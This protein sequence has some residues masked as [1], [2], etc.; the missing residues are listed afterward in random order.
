MGR[1]STGSI[2]GCII[3]TFFLDVGF[4]C[5]TPHTPTVFFF[6]FGGGLHAN[7]RLESTQSILG[8]ALQ[9]AGHFCGNGQTTNP[10]PPFSEQ[11]LQNSTGQT[12]RQT[13]PIGFESQIMPWSMVLQNGVGENDQGVS[14]LKHP[15]CHHQTSDG[16][17]RS[18]EWTCCTPRCPMARKPFGSLAT[19]AGSLEMLHPPTWSRARGKAMMVKPRRKA[20]SDPVPKDP[21]PVG[22]CWYLEGQDTSRNPGQKR[23]D[24][25]HAMF[26]W[27]VAFLSFMPQLYVERGARTYLPTWSKVLRSLTKGSQ[28]ICHKYP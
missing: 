10:K 2:F 27:C 6:F 1:S 25:F 13:D 21:E 9:T 3:F 28:I 22:C 15:I 24:I 20:W 17:R 5:L 23:H 11:G 4:G 8:Y 18:L 19:P 16:L 7:A 12:L 26:W 14:A